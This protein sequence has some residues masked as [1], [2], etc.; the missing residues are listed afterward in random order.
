MPAVHYQDTK[1]AVGTSVS[2]ICLALRLGSA[3]R[4]SLP[5]SRLPRGP[6]Y[7]TVRLPCG[8]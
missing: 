7:L 3:S 1:V 6:Q 4:S 2:N 8:P 5:L